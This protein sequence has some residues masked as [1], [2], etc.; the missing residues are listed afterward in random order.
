MQKELSSSR[1][2]PYKDTVFRSKPQK[3]A[4]VESL[5]TGVRGGAGG[6]VEGKLVPLPGGIDIFLILLYNRK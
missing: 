4:F 5:E 6:R 2:A 3:I 1:S